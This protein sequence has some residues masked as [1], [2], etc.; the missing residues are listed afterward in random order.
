MG[1]A[2]GVDAGAAP[3]LVE[4]I[5][6]IEEG[7]VLV[8]NGDTRTWDVTDVV[9]RSIEDPTD[10]RE[11]KRVLRLNARSAVFG[12]ELVSYPDHHEASLH[13]LESPDWTEDGRVFDVD[14]VEVLTQRVPWVVVSGGPAAKYHFPDPQA[15]A[16]G[17]AAPACGAGN[18]GSTYRITRCNA[19]VPAY[20]GCKD[21]LRHAKPVGLQPVQCPDCGK[22]ICQGILQGEQVAAVDGFSITCPQCEFDGTVEVAFEN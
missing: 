22:H 13:A 19:V 14:D 20:S 17:E 11:S 16:Y 15:A 5:Q 9:E 10:D 2:A 18:Q 6:A 3:A 1:T 7:D 8:V 21:C 4:T 12:L